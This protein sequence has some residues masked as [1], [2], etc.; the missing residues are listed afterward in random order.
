LFY[1]GPDGQVRVEVFLADENIWLTQRQIADLFEVDVRTVSDH[2]KTIYDIGE[3]SSQATI[4]KNRIVQMEG[5][6]E[7]DR[8]LNLYSLDAIISVGYRV[9]SRQATQFR[10][11]A[12]KT[13]RDFIIKGFVLDE[14]RLKNGSHFGRDYFDELLEKIREIRASE[15]RFYLKITDIY[16]TAVDYDRKADITKEF[17]A[18]VQNKLHFAIH[19]QTAAELIASEADSTKPHMGLK[20]WKNSPKGKILKS[21]VVVAKNYLGEKQL[22]ELNRV[23]SMYLDF[24]ENQAERH[25]ALTM[26]DWADRLDAFLQF[27]EYDILHSPGKVSKATAECLAYNEYK[28][29]RPLQ[30]NDYISDFEEEVKKLEKQD[31]KK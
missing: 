22:K 16:A 31:H 23:V 6:R 12:T 4:R 30:D 18:T 29:F 1:T 26:S 19:G 13:L 25:I 24:A 7:V 17:F 9:N 10:I 28:K 27:T 8:E 21:D 2:L 3:L 15:R 20:T 11:W 5:G 14:E